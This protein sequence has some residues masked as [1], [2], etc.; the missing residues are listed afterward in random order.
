M[1]SVLNIAVQEKHKGTPKKYRFVGS[2]GGGGGGGNRQDSCRDGEG[3][4]E[5]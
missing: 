3:E 4:G 5:Y 2:W 1:F